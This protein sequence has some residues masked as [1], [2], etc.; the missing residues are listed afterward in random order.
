[1]Y[2]KHAHTTNTNNNTYLSWRTPNDFSSKLWRWE[3]AAL[4]LRLL[5]ETDDE[6]LKKYVNWKTVSVELFCGGFNYLCLV[7]GFKYENK[8]RNQSGTNHNSSYIFEFNKMSA[9][10]IDE[11]M[12]VYNDL[13]AD[14]QV[15]FTAK[16]QTLSQF[17]ENTLVKG[18]ILH[19][20]L[21]SWLYIYIYIQYL[22][23]SLIY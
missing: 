19:R 15:L 2:C 17:N 8:N 20:L 14:I 10:L 6:I 18:V 13:R 4:S 21:A 11:K 12:K 23:I 16:Q 7:N 3:S 22:S 5:T 1:M 9:A